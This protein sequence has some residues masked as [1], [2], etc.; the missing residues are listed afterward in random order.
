MPACYP[1][2]CPAGLIRALLQSPASK[3]RKLVERHYTPECRMTHALGEGPIDLPSA[4]ARIADAGLG[5]QLPCI[6]P[7]FVHLVSQ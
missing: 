2:C 5:S 1:L 7:H 6:R 3:Q 4:S